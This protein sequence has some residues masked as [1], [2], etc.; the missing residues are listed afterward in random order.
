MIRNSWK[1]MSTSSS[2]GRRWSSTNSQKAMKEYD[3]SP[4]KTPVISR[5]SSSTSIASTK[6]EPAWRH[7]RHIPVNT[8]AGDINE[9]RQRRE[10][11][12]KPSVPTHAQK[13][14]LSRLFSHEKDPEKE[15]EKERKRKAKDLKYRE[16]QKVLM[17][18]KYAAEV[19]VK[20]LMDPAYREHIKKH[21]KPRVKT[22][23]YRGEGVQA[24]STSAI[25]EMR[26]PH[27]GP[28]AVHGALDLPVLSKIES[29]DEPDQLDQW[30]QLRR[31]WNEAKEHNLG[32]VEEIRSR[33][34][35][36][37]VSPMASRMGSRAGS[38]LGS[39]AG[40]RVVSREGSPTRRPAL[41]SKRSS[42]AGGYFRDGAGRWTRKTP[43]EG[44]TP[45]QVRGGGINPDLLAASLVEKLKTSA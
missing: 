30:E 44:H 34:G 43:P 22:A 2:S 13:K 4:A 23:A 8:N 15:K 10:S 36:R 6:S 16:E 32:D 18:S 5:T 14:G 25:Q 42:W 35:S 45:P 40:S 21:E 29:H 19:R 39:R 7:D 1:K 37:V 24:I 28:V 41:G 20:M 9:L 3:H 12:S 27:S 38:P 31:D 33:A 26:Y 17:T 11:L